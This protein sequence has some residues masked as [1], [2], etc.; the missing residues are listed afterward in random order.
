MTAHALQG[1]RDEC[2]EAGMDDYVTK[3]V[4]SAE[5][6]RV[7][8]SVVAE[9]PGSAGAFADAAARSRGRP[10]RRP[11]RLAETGRNGLPSLFAAVRAMT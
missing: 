11:R 7:L 6:F 10:R 4:Q 8:E 1:I 5:L 9:H 2:F 3:P